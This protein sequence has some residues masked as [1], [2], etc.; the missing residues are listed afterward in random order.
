MT[1]AL[2]QK[3]YVRAASVIKV[4]VAKVLTKRKRVRLLPPRADIKVSYFYRCIIFS[5]AVYTYTLL[6]SG[7]TLQ[8]LYPSNTCMLLCIHRLTPSCV[9]E[10]RGQYPSRI[11]RCIEGCHLRGSVVV[12]PRIL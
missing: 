8:Y 9:M 10:K 11:S 7:R 1:V 3:E 6:Q 5:F 4:A 12:G 2:S